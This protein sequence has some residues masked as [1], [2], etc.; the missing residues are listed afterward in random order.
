ML[1]SFFRK[2]KSR[3]RTDLYSFI[4]ILFKFVQVI[5]FNLDYVKFDH[6]SI[7]SSFFVSLHKTIANIHI[8]IL[9]FPSISL[10]TYVSYL[11]QTTEVVKAKTR[12]K[13]IVVQ[14]EHKGTR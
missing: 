6:M 10:Y 2:K 7:F 3:M 13:F 4:F 1:F 12:K 14:N 9:F 5:L 11:G 8:S